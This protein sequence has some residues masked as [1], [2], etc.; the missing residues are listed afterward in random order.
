MTVTQQSYLVKHPVR[1]AKHL[2]ESVQPTVEEGKE[3]QEENQ[4]SCT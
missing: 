1:K 4:H 3:R 2:G